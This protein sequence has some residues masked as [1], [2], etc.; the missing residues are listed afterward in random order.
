VFEKLDRLA[1]DGALEE[2]IRLARQAL[3][4]AEGQDALELH[5]YLSWA[6]FELEDFANALE[7]GRAADDPLDEAKPLFHLW[8]FDEARRAL[9][10]CDDEAE[11]HWYKALVA[12]FT[13]GDPRPELRRAI[14]LEPTRYREPARLTAE[15]VDRVV[16]GALH[17]L[18]GSLAWIAQETV[19]EV[20]PLPEPHPDVD[21]LTLGIY[22]GTDIA[23][24]SHQDGVTIP[25]RIEIYQSN[26]ERI[27]LEPSEASRELRVTLLHELGH[28]FG[29]GEEDMGRLGLE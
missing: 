1:E 28:H 14:A 22:L 8:R 12:E 5:H 25:P 10:E 29:F 18:P 17:A 24:R 11:A 19:I 27:A 20:L 9:D 23:T 3:R 26:I 6:Y 16:A 7:E 15:E 13:G 21:P 2:M 4:D